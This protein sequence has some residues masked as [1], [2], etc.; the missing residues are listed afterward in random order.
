[1]ANKISGIK[2]QRHEVVYQ[3]FRPTFSVWFWPIVLTVVVWIPLAWWRRQNV[4]YI[5]TN[6]R[7]ITRHGLLRSTSEEFQFSDVSR[8]E[9]SKSL[10]E[11]VLGGGTITVDTGTDE[12]TLRAVPNHR[13]VAA[14]IRK[15]Q[16]S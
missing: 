5:I 10:G 8:L 15:G 6:E 7:V 9:T 3:S 14:T 4:R 12:L 1:M 11:R 13:A 2:L 16:A